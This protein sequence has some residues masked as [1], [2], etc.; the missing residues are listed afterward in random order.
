MLS[1]VTRLTAQRWFW[2]SFATLLFGVHI[3]TSRFHEQ[4]Y[5]AQ[6]YWGLA[7]TMYNE[8]HF[9]LLKF[10]SALRGYLLP[11]LYVPVL[12][13]SN[14]QTAVTDETLIK[15]L[16]T[17]LAGLLF[18]V[19]V[20]KLWQKATGTS[21][22]PLRRLLFITAAFLLW[23]DYFNYTLTDFPAVAG[24][25]GA[26]CLLLPRP[27]AGRTLLAGILIGGI[28]N[29]RPI[30][31]ASTPLVALLIG[32]LAVQLAR[33]DRYAQAVK[34][35]AVYLAGFAL[36]CIPQWHINQRN[37][38]SN[39]LLPIGINLEDP[40]MVKS[41]DLYL[42]QMNGG[43]FIQKYE[44]SI[45]ADYPIPQARYHDAAGARLLDL[46]PNRQIASYG[47]YFRLFIAHPLDIIALNLRHV[48]NGLDVLYPTPYL[49]RVYTSTSGVAFFNYT[50]LFAAAATV[51]LRVRRVR[52]LQWAIVLPILAPAGL[53]VPLPMEC[54]YLM[55][56]HLVLFAVACFGWPATWTWQ[57][58]K[59][60]RLPFIL[61]YVFFLG[62]CFMLSADTQVQLEEGLKLLS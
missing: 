21:I 4:V 31:L 58:L 16:G 55:P 45:A 23:R 12:A 62:V 7:K 49:F 52:V 28:T 51:V 43:F 47:D 9:S 10:D 18:G 32:V 3:F 1:F 13:L 42:Q 30:Y 56:A 26:L 20:P 61:A 29:I 44:T 54:R 57:R 40:A 46:A 53:M 27:T 50:V 22:S 24:L 8:G 41:G 15:L 39:R 19:Q 48:F 33:P 2:F 6:G 38:A 5:D 35:L 17:L 59:D 36:V 25:V 37:F 14:W 34:L 60:W 11:L